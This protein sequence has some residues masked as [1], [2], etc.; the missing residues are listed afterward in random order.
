[1]TNLY[2]FVI[3]LMEIIKHIVLI[4]IDSKFETFSN[5]QV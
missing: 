4:D 3:F 5:K 2:R 1:M